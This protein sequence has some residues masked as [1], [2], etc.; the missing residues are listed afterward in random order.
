[1]S[2][3]AP[4][5]GSKTELAGTPDLSGRTPVIIMTW[6]G[7]VSITGSDLAAGK[8][9]PSARSAAAGGQGGV[10]SSGRQP[11]TTRT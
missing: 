2:L 8:L 7:I 5:A 11:S 4:S 10:I 9:V 6:L 3:A 1:M